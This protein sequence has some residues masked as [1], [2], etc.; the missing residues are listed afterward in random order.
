MSE[1]KATIRW[2]RETKDF[3]YDTFD[4]THD[5]V[6]EGGTR[7]KASSAKEFLGNAALVNPEELLAAALSNCH[8]LTF[9]AIAAKSRLIV[10]S[11]EDTAVALLDKNSAGKFAVT[12]TTLRP[13]VTFAKET[14][15]APEKIAE[16]HEKAHRNCFIANSVACEVV[17]EPVL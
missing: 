5:I 17:T 11:Y 6:F 15:V 9:L 2:K 16:L 3:A 7:C 14:P 10:D 13:K 4:R 12:K 1:H 8:M